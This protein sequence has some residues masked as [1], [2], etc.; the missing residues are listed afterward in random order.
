MGAERPTMKTYQAIATLHA[1][2]ENCKRTGNTEWE[3]RHGE[4]LDR[5][6]SRG[7]GGSGF[8]AGFSLDHVSNVKIVFSTSFHHMDGHG[9][10]SGW[11]R[12]RVTVRACLR[13]GYSLSISGRNRNDVKE[14]MAETWCAWLDSDAE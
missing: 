14:Y 10:Y 13:D 5:I 4:R 9:Y 12:H 1:A 8:D 11:T 3:D 7:P 6:L 2:I